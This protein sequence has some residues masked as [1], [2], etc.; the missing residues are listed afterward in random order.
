MFGNTLYSRKGA[1]ALLLLGL[2]L[3]LVITHA[4]A[5]TA[6][7]ESQPQIHFGLANPPLVPANCNRTGGSGGL[8]PGSHQTTVAGVKAIVVV[9]KGYTPK[10]PTYLG[11]YL[12]GDGAVYDG[13]Q[14]STSP[15]NQFANR[16]GWII[17]SP[18]APN[19][20]SWWENPKGDQKQA[21]AN[22]LDKMFSQYNVCRHI[23]FGTTGSGGSEFWTRQF[24][25]EK[26]GKYPA[27]TVIACGGNKGD[28]Q[29]LST[30]GKNSDVVARA[31]FYYVYG[32]EDSL[33]SLILS[34]IKSYTSAGFDVRIKKLVGAGHC[35]KWRD[36]GLP[37]W[38]EWTVTYW[39]TMAKELG[40]AIN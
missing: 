15:I 27:H 35:N 33:L 30:L 8:Q 25:P 36:Q 9:G 22:V 10:N 12:H 21:F 4:P 14:K 26:G 31:T 24:F 37:T 11:F 3:F 13:V 6:Q 2:A 7:P 19:G 18:L 32:T 38:P 28:S 34:S 20:Q 1:S 16:N 40:V 17:V 5:V 23:V 29:K 39:T